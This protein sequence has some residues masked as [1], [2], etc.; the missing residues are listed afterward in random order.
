MADLPPIPAWWDCERHT[1]PQ[2]EWTRE[3]PCRT[4][5]AER[6]AQVAA[7]VEAASEFQAAHL[8]VR[9]TDCAIYRQLSAALVP[10]LEGSK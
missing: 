7:L 2:S 10:F 6:E 5:T 8:C 3:K 4:C 1:A 9:P